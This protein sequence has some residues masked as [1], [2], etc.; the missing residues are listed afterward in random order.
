MLHT[1]LTKEAMYNFSNADLYSAA[2]DIAEKLSQ[3]KWADRGIGFVEWSK[4]V[5]E[6]NN[7]TELRRPK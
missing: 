4:L 3:L 5:D 7:I 6:L 2:Y 1:K